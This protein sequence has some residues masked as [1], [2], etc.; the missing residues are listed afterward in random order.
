VWGYV[1]AKIFVPALPA[2]LEELRTR[3]TEAVTATDV[4]MIHMIWNEIPYRW[5]ICRVTRGNHIEQ[6]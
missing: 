6:L 2:R 3:I 4:D 5:D 1:K